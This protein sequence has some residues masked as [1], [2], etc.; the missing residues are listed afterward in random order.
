MALSRID[1]HFPPVGAPTLLRAV[2]SLADGADRL[3]AEAV[4][5]TEGGSLEV[6]LP[7]EVGDYRS[8]FS[9]VESL[10]QFDSLLARA[11]VVVVA[12]QQ[13]MRDEAYQRVG[14]Y[15]VDRC[16]VLIAVWDG[17]GS[18]GRGGTADVVA[19]A[20]RKRVPV[21]IVPT[22]GAEPA[23]DLGEGIP[24]LAFS[25]ANAD[26]LP[27]QPGVDGM[28]LLPIDA[29]RATQRELAQYNHSS[30]GRQKLRPENFEAEVAKEGHSVPVDDGLG[31]A[32]RELE[33]WILAYFVRADRLAIVYQSWYYR[34]ITVGFI[35]AAMAVLTVASV[36]LFAGRDDQGY[37]ALELVFLALIIFVYFV[38]RRLELHN[39]W[40]SARFLAE[41][42]RSMVFLKAAGLNNRRE[43]G[44]EGVNLADQSEEWLRRAYAYVWDAC[45]QVDV[46]PSDVTELRSLLINAWIHHQ[47]KYHASR[48]A[49]HRGRYLV[50]TSISGGLFVVTAVVAI[51]HAT[52][53]L[54]GG[55]S[56]LELASIALPAFGS[57]VAGIS[58]QR[59]YQ[60]NA[61][62]YAR[63]ASQL[64]S[65]EIRMSRA[66]TLGEVQATAAAVDDIMGDENR[67]W[68]GVMKFNDFEISG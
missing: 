37:A 12:P 22:N 14:E 49:R 11:A 30:F 18:R 19:Y 3:L 10:N 68:L 39:R 47:A 5:A 45:P 56:S 24:S 61:T 65:A 26:R 34:L 41:R 4:L 50:L 6:P 29:T 42:L 28:R 63:M 7:F 48:S 16:D 36:T 58:A 32:L 57:A 55:E 31:H 27:W 66:Q 44:F 59:Q 46:T 17:E 23:E 21:L 13:E 1:E 43:G 2:S 25:G 20:L 64:N 60:R 15:V 54:S 35:A 33:D 53:A 40:L 9:T 67:D 8:D 51:L 38:G 62:V 52:E